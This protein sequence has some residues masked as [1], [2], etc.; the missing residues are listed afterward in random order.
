[1]DWTLAIDKNREALKR[2]VAMLIGMAGLGTPSL[3]PLWEKVSPSSEQSEDGRRMRGA[4]GTAD[5]AGRPTLPR[6]L[7]RAILRLLRPA[8]SATRRLIIIAA[9]DVVI[10]PS[11][12]RPAKPKP[13][14]IV[15]RDGTG[16][17]MRRGVLPARPRPAPRAMSLPL[18]DPD[19]HYFRLRQPVLTSVPRISFPGLVERSPIPLRRPPA[20]GDPLDATRL[21]L[22]L[23]ALATALDDLPR[24][25]R[26]LAR[27]KANRDAEVARNRNTARRLGRLSPLRP[28]RPPGSIRRPK[29]EVHEL[30]KD[31]HGLAIDVLHPDTS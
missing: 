26:R 13:V 9:R 20:P 5:V 2:I 25:A 17:V 18:F 16:I 4:G 22:R 29:H 15:L 30:L 19:K 1:M 23:D 21:T 6:Q 3:R 8:E 11:P 7:H 10:P 24:Q 14:S 31:L 27:W 12:P 28:G